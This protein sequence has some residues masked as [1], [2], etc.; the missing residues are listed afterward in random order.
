MS[1]FCSWKNVIQVETGIYGIKENHRLL[2]YDANGYGLDF[3]FKMGLFMEK[4]ELIADLYQNED[5]TT[6]YSSINK[7]H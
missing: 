1:F 2:E 6:P 3:T 4:L 5:F 7:S